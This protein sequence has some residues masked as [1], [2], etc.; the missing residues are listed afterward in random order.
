MDAT[1]NPMRRRFGSDKRARYDRVFLRSD[2]RSWTPESASLFA[3]DP[4]DAEANVLVS[5]HFGVFTVL[6]GARTDDPR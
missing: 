5:D 6:R 4:V 1:R 2:D 3:D